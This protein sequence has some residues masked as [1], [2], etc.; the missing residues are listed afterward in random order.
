MGQVMP[1]WVGRADPAEV[2]GRLAE[3][4]GASAAQAAP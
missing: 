3:R 4:L 1:A 2:R